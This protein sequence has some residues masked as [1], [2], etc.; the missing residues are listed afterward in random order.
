MVALPTA[1]EPQHRKELI[2]LS[3][4]ALTRK[5]VVLELIHATVAAKQSTKQRT[6][7]RREI[8]H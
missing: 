8:E 2:A 1:E 7:L 5:S 6:V 4:S 3:V